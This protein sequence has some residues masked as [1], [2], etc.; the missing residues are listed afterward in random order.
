MIE[1]M[2]KNHLIFCLFAAAV[3]FSMVREWSAPVACSRSILIPAA[4]HRLSR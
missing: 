2:R 1:M 4:A 3:L